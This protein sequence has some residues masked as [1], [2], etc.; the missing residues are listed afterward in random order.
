MASPNRPATVGEM[1]EKVASLLDAG[2]A[3]FRALESHTG[4]KAPM[5]GE[6]FVQ[7]D[8]RALAAGLS[9]NRELDAQVMALLT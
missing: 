2:E 9:A 4:K 7:Q 3:A 8:L 6:K 5:S 1:L